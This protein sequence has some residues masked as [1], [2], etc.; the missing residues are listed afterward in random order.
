MLLFS[1]SVMSDSL[2]PHGLQHTRLPCPSTPPGVCSN[3]HPL[4]WWLHPII[5]SSV[6]PFSSCLQSFPASV[7][8]RYSALR[9]RWPKYWSFSFSI[10]PLGLTCWIS[11]QSKGLSRVSSSTTVWKFQFFGAQ[12][13]LWSNSHNLIISQSPTS[14]HCTLGL[15]LHPWIQRDTVQFIA[16]CGV[17]WQ[18]PCMWERHKNSASCHLFTKY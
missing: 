16:A 7:F 9:I 2:Q 4:I 18:V 11:L 14:K 15:G 8:S 13:S 17:I 10:S 3:S 1:Y 6:V 5:S 12:P